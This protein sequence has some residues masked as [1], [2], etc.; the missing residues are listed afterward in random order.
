MRPPIKLPTKQVIC[1]LG[2]LCRQVC[3]LPFPSTILSAIRQL[4]L[5]PKKLLNTHAPW[6]P[7][8]NVD[9]LQKE[10]MGL[11]NI[12]HHDPHT[13]VTW[14]VLI[15]KLTCLLYD[16]GQLLSEMGQLT[17]SCVFKLHMSKFGLWKSGWAKPDQPGCLLCYSHVITYSRYTWNCQVLKC[18]IHEL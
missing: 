4:H 11:A 2:I 15:I 1:W 8:L 13:A 9:P 16:D 7:S 6:H 17:S 18:D 12:V 10:K 14:I 3:T 5:P